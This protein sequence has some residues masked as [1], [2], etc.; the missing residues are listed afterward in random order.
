MTT[1]AVPPT[2][3]ATA[4]ETS[5][6]GFAVIAWLVA[7][8]KQKKS[9]HLSG[10]LRTDDNCSSSWKRLQLMLIIVSFSL[11]GSTV[12]T[13]AAKKKT[14]RVRV[15][16]HIGALCVDSKNFVLDELVPTYGVL[17][18]AVMDLSAASSGKCV[19][20][21]YKSIFTLQRMPIWTST[22]GWCWWSIWRAQF[23]LV[24]VSNIIGLGCCRN[25]LL[26]FCN[27][28]GL[29]GER[30]SGHEIMITPLDAFLR[31]SE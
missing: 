10:Q 15:D 19:Q 11:L 24:C 13:D 21:I 18:S 30:C 26:S 6:A 1:V 27:G 25:I 4:T 8:S 29:G 2:S 7:A 14:P 20:V 12:D 28:G 23:H 22:N 16:M 3:T 31:L 5:T 17:G 9:Q